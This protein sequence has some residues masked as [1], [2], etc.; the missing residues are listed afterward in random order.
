MS[1]PFALTTNM[2]CS[3]NSFCR[4][5]QR[6]RGGVFFFWLRSC[7]IQTPRHPPGKQCTQWQAG[8][9]SRGQSQ[10]VGRRPGDGARVANGSRSSSGASTECPDQLALHVAHACANLDQT[11]RRSKPRTTI[12]S[13]SCAFKSRHHSL[14]SR[15]RLVRPILAAHPSTSSYPRRRCRKRMSRQISLCT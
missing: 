13:T 14:L 2:V 6:T 11:P 15:H 7:N 12:R 10:A 4:S 8:V 5:L 3:C 9:R 1:E